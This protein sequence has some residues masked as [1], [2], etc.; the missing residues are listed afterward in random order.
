M[1]MRKYVDPAGRA[2]AEHLLLVNR[3]GAR[4]MDTTQVPLTFGARFLDDVR[5][6]TETAIPQERS[7]LVTRL[8]T[9]ASQLA[10]RLDAA[11][12]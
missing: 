1:E 11:V 3:D 4:F 7:F 10:Q 5:N 2:G 12:S 8:S 9:E 6:R